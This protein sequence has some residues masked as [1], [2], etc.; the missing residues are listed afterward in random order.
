MALSKLMSTTSW[1]CIEA[2][3]SSAGSIKEIPKEYKLGY[4]DTGIDIL[5][6]GEDE[7]SHMLLIRR[8]SFILRW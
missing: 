8:R 1:S 4:G 5:C 3:L 2:S 6:P 7:H